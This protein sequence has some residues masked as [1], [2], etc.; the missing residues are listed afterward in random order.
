MH[1]NTSCVS[2]RA[3]YNASTGVLGSSGLTCHADNLP[4][5]NESQPVVY[6]AGVPEGRR[7]DISGPKVRRRRSGPEIDSDDASREISE[8]DASLPGKWIV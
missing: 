2:D 7:A 1:L 8:R 6:I 3:E 5:C 4:R